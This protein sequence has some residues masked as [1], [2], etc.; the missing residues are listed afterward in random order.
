MCR[1]SIS[2]QG[3]ILGCDMDKLCII[4]RFRRLGWVLPDISENFGDVQKA[5]NY[6]SNILATSRRLYRFSQVYP[7]LRWTVSCFRSIC[8]E[9]GA[10]IRNWRISSHSGNS[11]TIVRTWPTRPKTLAV[12]SVVL[13]IYYIMEVLAQVRHS[14][15]TH[16]LEMGASK[17]RQQEKP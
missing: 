16:L 1:D 4:G 12:C 17:N 2:G 7:F 9:F 14:W 11:L 10:A 3:Y 5:V 8:H 13:K 6:Q 15:P